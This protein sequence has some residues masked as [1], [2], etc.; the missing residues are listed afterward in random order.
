MGS[1]NIVFYGLCAL[2]PRLPQSENIYGGVTV[3]LPNVPADEPVDK[4][5]VRRSPRQPDIPNGTINIKHEAK[6]HIRFN[7]SSPERIDLSAKEVRILINDSPISG[8]VTMKQDADDNKYPTSYIANLHEIYSDEGGINVKNGSLTGSLSANGLA[9][10]VNIH[11]GELAAYSATI[12]GNSTISAD[13][14]LFYDTNGNAIGSRR[15]LVDAVIF[16]SDLTEATKITIQIDGMSPK[17]YDPREGDLEL[18]FENM[19]PNNFTPTEDFTD[20]DFLLVYKVADTVFDTK[21]LRLPH[22][23]VDRKTITPFAG[24]PPAICGLAFYSPE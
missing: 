20:V 14:Y 13:T 3:L 10:R 16:S 19:P 11:N 6:L 2:V 7:G 1:F 4:D 23:F 18:M 9:S 17:N 22:V 12:D 15:Q 21:K 24:R 5:K 8:N